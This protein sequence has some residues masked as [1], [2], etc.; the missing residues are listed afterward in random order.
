MLVTYCELL[1]YKQFGFLSVYL[2]RQIICFCV[3]QLGQFTPYLV[4]TSIMTPKQRSFEIR[5][6]VKLLLFLSCSAGSCFVGAQETHCRE[7]C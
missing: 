6:L 2:T 5:N 4:L 7:A 1:K 3:G